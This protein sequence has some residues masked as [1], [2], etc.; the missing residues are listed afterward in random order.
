MH[1]IAGLDL[2]SPPSHPP[3][4]PRVL[5]VEDDASA[6]GLLETLLARVG[7]QVFLARDGAEALRRLKQ[8]P[9]PDI[10]L[11]DWMLPETS[12]V[13]IC[14]RVRERWNELEMPVLMVTAKTD[15]ESISEAFAAGASDY[16]T[17][18]FLGVELR[19]RV[20]AHLRVKQLIEERARIDEHLMERE[21]LSA[22]GLLVSGVAHDLKNPLGGISGYTQLLLEEETDPVRQESLRR[23]MEE[24]Q[25]CDRIVGDLLSFAR[26]HPPQRINLDVGEVLRRTLE[27]R[28]RQLQSFGLRTR[29][30]IAEDLPLVSGDPH[31][32]QQ[33]F[34]N[35]VINA[36]HA[37]LHSGESLQI[38]AGRAVSS[39][40]RSDSIEWVVLTFY[41]DGPPIPPEVLPRIFQPFFTTKAEDEG[42]GLGLAICQRIVREHGGEMDV[43]SGS[44]GTTFRIFLPAVEETAI[45]PRV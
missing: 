44:D 35:I 1:R 21:K 2:E 5:V 13:E 29:L 37:L 18:P 31:Q 20:A 27:L 28:E 23:I 25:R 41:N 22:L 19:A 43:E 8:S 42:T 24:V 3:R 17:K 15:A 4:Q 9:M 36:E 7:Y 10:L 30:D 40:G 38:T 33:V 39:T 45:P 11:L 12:G 14:R 32:L 6:A 34:L 26:R 16:I